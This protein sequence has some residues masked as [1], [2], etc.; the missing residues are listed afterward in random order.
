MKSTTDQNKISMK[1][2]HLT[3]EGDTSIQKLDFLHAITCFSQALELSESSEDENKKY[4]ILHCLLQSS[5]AKLYLGDAK[6]ALIA[7]DR[8]FEQ[9]KEDEKC[10]NA[11]CESLFRKAEA[12]FHIGN[13]EDAL[14]YYHR[15]IHLD[16]KEDGE[17]HQGINKSIDAINQTLEAVDAD[18]LRKWKLEH[19]GRRKMSI[20]AKSFMA[21]GKKVIAETAEDTV[22]TQKQPQ[23]A[24]KH[25]PFSLHNHRQG[26]KNYLDELQEDKDFLEDLYNDPSM[27]DKN[28][29]STLRTI[30]GSLDYLSSREDFWRLREFQV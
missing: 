21:I 3:L 17:F 4:H 7:A 30:K 16:P 24:Q 18:H 29:S 13:F 28:L 1:I 12:Y 25:I 2:Q 14:M 8:A 6:G 27:Q 20:K 19:V 23:P 15:G 10:F 22:D 11:H 9:S 5:K 26:K